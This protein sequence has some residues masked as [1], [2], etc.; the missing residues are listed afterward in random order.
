MTGDVTG[1]VNPIEPKRDKPDAGVRPG[2]KRGRGPAIGK[3]Q[4]GIGEPGD[5][6]RKS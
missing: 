5:V 1:T 4:Q 3:L 6:C 2:L